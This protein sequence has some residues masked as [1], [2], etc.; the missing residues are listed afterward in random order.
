LNISSEKLVSSL[1][2]FKCNV[3]RYA[4]G[5]HDEAREVAER[6]LKAIPSAE[7]DE[8]M[9]VWVAYLNLENLHGKP[10]NR[11]ALL[12]LFDRATVGLYTLTHPVDP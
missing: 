5:A 8:R 6:A 3:Y 7:E 2:Y 12:R 1:C 4:A 9:N 10:T 11:E